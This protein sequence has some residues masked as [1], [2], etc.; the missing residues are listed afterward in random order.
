MEHTNERQ[1]VMDFMESSKNKPLTTDAI[2]NTALPE[3]NTDYVYELLSEV[4]D[5]GKIEKIEVD[6]DTRET[7]N[8]RYLG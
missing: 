5:K 1:A 2:K 3:K 6:G 8:W 4:A 7:T